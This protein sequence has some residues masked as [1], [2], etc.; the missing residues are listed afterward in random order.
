[1]II[2]EVIQQFTSRLGVDVIISVEVQANSAMGFDDT[3]QRAIKEN[4]KV[5]KLI[6]LSLRKNKAYAI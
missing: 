3:L 6:R 4:C 1:M 5:I 2:D